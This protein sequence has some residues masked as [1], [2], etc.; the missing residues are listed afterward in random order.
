[1]RSKSLAARSQGAGFCS[2]YEAGFEASLATASG[3]LMDANVEGIF[4]PLYPAQASPFLTQLPEALRGLPLVSADALLTPEFLVL[5]ESEGLYIAGPITTFGN[6][7]GVTGKS[8]AE[9]K[10]VIETAYGDTPGSFWQH[11][12]DATTLLL[13]AIRSVAEMQG[14][15]LYIDRAEL[16]MQLAATEGFQGLVGAISCDAF[17]D[18]GNGITNVY[19]HTDSSVTD[20]AELTVVYRYVP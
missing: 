18:C 19:R 14:G 12:Y 13:D 20:A 11:S 1:M 4:F 2:K 15:K 9:V 8:E 3:E 10:Q 7:N 5:E 16:R 17:G 6:V